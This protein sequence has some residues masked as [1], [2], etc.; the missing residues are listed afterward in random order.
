LTAIW[1][2]CCHTKLIL[3]CLSAFSQ[4]I[5]AIFNDVWQDT[6]TQPLSAVPSYCDTWQ[7]AW[8]NI[9]L[10]FWHTGTTPALMESIKVTF[11]IDFGCDIPL[12]PCPLWICRVWLV[13]SVASSH[14]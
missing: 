14:Y 13:A 4:W 10:G 7:S 6:F 2:Y 5:C 8:R 1:N 3:H 9:P 12:S 11:L